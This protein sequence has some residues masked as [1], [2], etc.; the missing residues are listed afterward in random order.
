M[1]LLYI[2]AGS[3]TFHAVG[4]II[5]QAQSVPALW[6]GGLILVLVG[7]ALKLGLAPFPM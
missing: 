1:A 5:K 6:L 3:M 2:Q 4:A 7:I